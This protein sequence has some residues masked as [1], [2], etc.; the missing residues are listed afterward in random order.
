MDVQN[1]DTSNHDELG[2]EAGQAPLLTTHHDHQQL[3]NVYVA[4]NA[5]ATNSSLVHSPADPSI[6]S[7][8]S[9]HGGVGFGHQNQ[10]GSGNTIDSSDRS[11]KIYLGERATGLID[12]KKSLP[13][14]GLYIGQVSGLTIQ[15]GQHGF[16]SSSQLP[17]ITCNSNHDPL[18]Q[19]LSEAGIR[20]ALNAKPSETWPALKNR[21]NFLSL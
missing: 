8:G 7:R 10:A 4:G 9:D 2:G 19:S 5:N 15:Y 21:E 13:S 20:L 18:A 14:G 11:I 12:D 16:S 3:H 6:N 17:P 1:E